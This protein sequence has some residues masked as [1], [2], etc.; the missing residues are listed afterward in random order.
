MAYRTRCS[1]REDGSYSLAYGKGSKQ[2]TAV[3]VKETK[4]WRVGEFVAVTKGEVVALWSAWAEKSY[5]NDPHPL[6]P[7]TMLLDDKE[8]AQART[9]G[10]P[11]RIG[12]AVPVSGGPPR[13]A[14][15]T[16]PPPVAAP[17]P[18]VEQLRADP[19][20]PQFR[21][22][23][24]HAFFPRETT[25]LGLLVEIKGWHDRY[26][27]RINDVNEALA[28]SDKWPPY[29]PFHALISALNDIIERECPNVN[30]PPES[31][32]TLGPA[33]YGPTQPIIH[34]TVIS[35]GVVADVDG[36]YVDPLAG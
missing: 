14:L 29:N 35:P 6:G 33:N 3:L 10:G 16:R 19:L 18:V 7:A 22:P 9:A 31:Q 13:V 27:E 36:T 28:Q 2:L 32:D 20:N 30:N 8:V 5:G 34:R 21:Y 23:A 4:Q 26:A 1:K 25:P 17:V 12:A 11:P 24:D 15:P